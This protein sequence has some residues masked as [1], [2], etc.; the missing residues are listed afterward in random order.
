MKKIEEATRRKIEGAMP[1][2]R[3]FWVNDREE[4]CHATGYEVF[5]M[6][7]WWDEYIDSNDEFHLGR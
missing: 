5:T 7:V 1:F 6:G 2:D 3:V 4:L